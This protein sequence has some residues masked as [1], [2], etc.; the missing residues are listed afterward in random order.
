MIGLSYCG[1][2]P[3][4]AHQEQKYFAFYNF[5]ILVVTTPFSVWT[6]SK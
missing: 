2:V 4:P 5:T 6:T 1:K 3:H